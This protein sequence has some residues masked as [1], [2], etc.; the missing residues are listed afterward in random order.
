MLSNI[1]QNV[2]FVLFFWVFILLIIGIFGNGF[3]LYASLY[4]KTLRTVANIPVICIL[5]ND[6]LAILVL[7]FQITIII[8]AAFIASL[9]SP[10][11]LCRVTQV[12][13]TISSLNQ[14]GLLIS[15][16]FDRLEAIRHPL[17][18]IKRLKRLK[19]NIT[20]IIACSGCFVISE[21][22]LNA[23]NLLGTLCDSNRTNTF[24]NLAFQC[25]WIFLILGTTI[26]A[27]VLYSMIL[28][29]I[30]RHMSTGNKKS[31]K[32]ASSNSE[33][34]KTDK[35][36]FRKKEKKMPDPKDVTVEEATTVCRK[37]HQKE[38]NID[39]IKDP[40]AGNEKDKEIALESEVV[41]FRRKKP[42]DKIKD[43]EEQ[44][45]EVEA[46]TVA[47]RRN[48]PKKEVVESKPNP[49][50]RKPSV[51]EE[52]ETET[53]AFKRHP[54]KKEE[55]KPNS[56][57]QKLSVINETETETVAFR[58]K[59]P[60][61][62]VAES[63]SNLESLQ[64]SKDVDAGTVAFRRN[65]PNK[66]AVES[67]PNS[68]SHKPLMIEEC[69]TETVA[70]K[71]NQ[72]KIEESKPTSEAQNPSVIN[73]TETETVAFR[74]K[75]LGQEVAESSPN[76]ESQKP[77]LI[78]ESDTETV[79][80]TRKPKP[81]TCS[82][83]PE[84]DNDNVVSFPRKKALKPNP[85]K[86]GEPDPQNPSSLAVPM[87]KFKI[88]NENGASVHSPEKQMKNENN[89]IVGNVCIV[90]KGNNE[91]SKRK[92]EARTGKRASL[93]LIVFVLAYSPLAIITG[94]YIHTIAFPSH[95]L[96]L[97]L[98]T[99]FFLICKI[100]T[101]SRVCF[102]LIILV[103]INRQYKL[104][105]KKITRKWKTAIQRSWIYKLVIAKRKPSK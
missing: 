31:N 32:V 91:N 83:N 79:V 40:T 35:V 36:V 20:V 55:T 7:P 5:L 80:F 41:V 85:A 58:R 90:K 68:E 43:A 30:H 78:N 89:G 12:F 9:D 75:P 33:P 16:S 4:S 14:M 99:T 6:L 103:F 47:F 76:S 94:V 24:L 77:Q 86:G 88:I 66:E 21:Q 87:K 46:E 23:G 2:S 45:K 62:V 74:R 44:V 13:D 81:Q 37:P 51:I 60:N 49:G 63:K 19:M 104:E 73:E 64:T 29:Y 39:N 15:I 84:T 54:P 67:K 57:A 38:S 28:Y 61:E 98:L 95:T 70:F 10:V 42:N 8:I 92:L 17:E 48:A 65:P 105:F 50:L 93:T 96:N 59:P 82:S 56:E 102:N 97:N 100:I 27:S 53:V 18:G 101:W 72:P 1:S 25:M 34:K 22:V 69:D 71:R 26:A 11:W 3:A 52:C